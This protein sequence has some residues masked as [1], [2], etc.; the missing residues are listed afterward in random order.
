MV[1]L[2]L[3]ILCGANIDDHESAVLLHAQGLQAEL[4]GQ[5]DDTFKAL[6]KAHA[7]APNDGDIAFDL[8]RVAM[9][10][11]ALTYDSDT[12]DFIAL[13]PVNADARVLRA[14]LLALHREVHAAQKEIDEALALEP[15]HPEALAARTMLTGLH[16][17]TDT[18]LLGLRLRLSGEFDSDVAL[19][20]QNVP[21]SAVGAR[22][23]VDAGLRWTPMRGQWRLDVNLDG[24]AAV[25]VNDRVILAPYDVF[26]GTGWATL[27]WDPGSWKVTLD[28]VGALVFA[29]EHSDPFLSDGY[30]LLEV[31]KPLDAFAVGVYGL[32]GYRNYGLNNAPGANDRT[33]AYDEVGALGEW[34]EGSFAAAVRGGY[35]QENAAGDL[36]KVHGAIGAVVG[37]WTH[38]DWTVAAALTYTFRDYYQSPYNRHDNR[39]EPAVQAT[40]TLS[41]R[42]HLVGSYVFFDV[43]SLEPYTY[44][45]HL[46]EL[47]VEATW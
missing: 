32:A 30:A 31:R 40:Y 33:G 15:A 22:T 44:Q 18:G 10:H 16:P 25:H 34:Q 4:N 47:G 9:L 29:G 8:A 24:R 39:V 35:L 20:P 37:R 1:L 23:A 45:R 2:A 42:V 11:P 12:D 27:T 17:G 36:Q 6:R 14:Y 5:V 41:D 28:A 21:T 46:A 19:L 3:F 43:R 26:S 38:P 13:E 7:L